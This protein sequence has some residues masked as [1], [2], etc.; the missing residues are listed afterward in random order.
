[1]QTFALIENIKHDGRF[2]RSCIEMRLHFILALLLSI[3]RTRIAALFFH[4]DHAQNGFYRIVA[5]P[6]GPSYTF[7]LTSAM[8]EAFSLPCRGG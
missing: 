6:D 7:N 4:D 1:M 2:S 8:E 5:H 3:Q